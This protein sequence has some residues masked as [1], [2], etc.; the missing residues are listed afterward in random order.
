LSLTGFPPDSYIADL[1]QGSRTLNSDGIVISD[2]AEGT[3][4]VTVDPRG[5][6]V[7]GTVLKPTGEPQERAV[8][9]LVP[10]PSMRGNP[11]RY[12][13]VLGDASGK[14]SIRGL[15]PGEYKAFAWNGIPGTVAEQ[16]AE[17]LAPIESKGISV[18]ILAGASQT[19]K[20]TALPNQ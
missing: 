9:A 10:A 13:R 12:G 2:P 15:A 17:F 6:T 5:G 20:L 3:V 14:F 16:N 11:M 7:E 19:L 18:T 8:V 1:R 4:E